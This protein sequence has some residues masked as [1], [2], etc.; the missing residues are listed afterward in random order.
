MYD[1]EIPST[2][3]TT[4][5]CTVHAAYSLYFDIFSRCLENYFRQDFFLYIAALLGSCPRPLL[6]I[7]LTIGHCLFAINSELLSL[8]QRTHA[9]YVNHAN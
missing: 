9:N 3:P 1:C 8:T 7:V 5:M 2:R 6:Q 4:P